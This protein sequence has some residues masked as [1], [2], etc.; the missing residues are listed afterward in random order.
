MQLLAQITAL[1]NHL[2]WQDSIALID[3][4]VFQQSNIIGYRQITDAYLLSLAIHHQGQ[5]VSFYKELV[6]LLP[7]QYQDGLNILD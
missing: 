7:K 3:S 2:F 4:I 1:P 5:L 6:S